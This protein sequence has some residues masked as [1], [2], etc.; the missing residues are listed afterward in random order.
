[1]V[2]VE[3]MDHSPEGRQAPTNGPETINPDDWF[4]NCG[5]HGQQHPKIDTI[6]QWDEEIARGLNKEEFWTGN[7]PHCNSTFE[8]HKQQDEFEDVLITK[9]TSEHK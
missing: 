1:M 5:V 6:Q 8:A 4:V 7:C 3:D 2:Y 9:S